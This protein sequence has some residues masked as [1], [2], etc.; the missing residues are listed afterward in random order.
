MV[1]V[2]FSG[3]EPVGS[4]ESLGRCFLSKPQILTGSWQAVRIVQW[5]GD[6]RDHLAWS[7]NRPLV[8]SLDLES[9]LESHVM[10]M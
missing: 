6:T 7:A 1:D 2:K 8:V 5:E 9:S 10:H 3:G 4:E